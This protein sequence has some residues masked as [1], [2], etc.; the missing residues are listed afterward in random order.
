M[1]M[2]NDD[3]NKKV[4]TLCW[5]SLACMVV[6]FI[7][8]VFYS[9]FLENTAMEKNEILSGIF[10]FIFTLAEILGV[11]LMLYVRIK[12]P[13]NI[14]GKVVMWLYIIALVIIILLI[15]FVITLCDGC[16]T[17]LVGCGDE[18]RGCDS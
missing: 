6:P 2:N 12:Y 9:S 15:I 11:V 13:K 1:N 8:T 7:L 18:I 14:F 5:I 10:E 17:G 4:N 16:I 3:S